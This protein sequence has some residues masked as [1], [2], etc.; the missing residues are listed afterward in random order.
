MSGK[1]GS[2]VLFIRH[3]PRDVSRRDLKAFVHSELR[4]AGVRGTLLL[5]LRSSFSILRITDLAK[6]SEEYQG[7]V[8][9]QPARLAL[10]A[11]DLLNGKHLCGKP[12]EVRRYRHRSPWG[13]HRARREDGTSGGYESAGHE[14][15]PMIERRRQNLKIELVESTPMLERHTATPALG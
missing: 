10:Q 5:H 6:G 2:I 14:V 7:L 8:E 1:S 9:I 4:R 13:E 3:L 15:T 11:I 12:V